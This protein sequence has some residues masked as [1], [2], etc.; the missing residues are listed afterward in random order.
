PATESPPRPNH[1]IN[2]RCMLSSHP[3]DPAT[4]HSSIAMPMNVQPIPTISDRINDIRRKTASIVN[5]EILPNEGKLWAW[6][7][8]GRYSESEVQ[9]SRHLRENVKQRVKADGLWAPHLPAGLRRLRPRLPRA[10][11]HERNPQLSHRR[12]H[13]VRPSSP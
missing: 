9:E 3:H 12:R 4:P 6:R 7:D 1:F 5:E 10:R 11:L 8:G 2:R 13:D